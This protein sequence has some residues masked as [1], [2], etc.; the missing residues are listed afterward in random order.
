MEEQEEWRRIDGW[1]YDVSSAGR[2]RRSLDSPIGAGRLVRPVREYVRVGLTKPGKRGIYCVHLLVAGAFL[3]SRPKNQKANH[4]DGDKGNCRADNLEWLTRN[5]NQIHA[6]KMGLAGSG[7]NHGRAK[8]TDEQV[9]EIRASYQGAWGEQSRIAERYGVSQGLITKI[10]RGEVWT[11]LDP[12]Y[13]PKGCSDVRSPKA[14]E[15]HGRAK[16]SSRN[17]RAI[18]RQHEKGVS[19]SRLAKRYIVGEPVIRD[20]VYGKTWQ[21]V[22]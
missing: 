15:K 9:R 13:V 10:V 4:K 11:H 14:G 7:E 21:Q 3:P 5:A 19:I 22:E 12:D 6:Y 16:L 17:V 20:I 8:L 1:P 18:R 2:V